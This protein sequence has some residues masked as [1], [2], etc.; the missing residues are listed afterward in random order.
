MEPV[1]DTGFLEALADAIVR[2]VE[3]MQSQRRRVY[4]LDQAA[5]YL[6]IS[7]NAVYDLVRTGKLRPVHLDSRNRF[8]IRD[9]DKLVDEMK[10]GDEA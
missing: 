10:N 7:D 8:D 5:E 9:L 2:R 3:T 1:K 4:K 6:G